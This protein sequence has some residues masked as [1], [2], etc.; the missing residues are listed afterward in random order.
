MNILLL[1]GYAFLGRA[2]GAARLLHDRIERY[3]YVSSVSVGSL[4]ATERFIAGF[5]CVG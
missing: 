5:A 4:P 1:G 3:V 2:I